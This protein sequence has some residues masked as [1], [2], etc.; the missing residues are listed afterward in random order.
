MLS[1]PLNERLIAFM[2]PMH[3]PTIDAAHTFH[4]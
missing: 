3:E 1:H 4:W 2:L